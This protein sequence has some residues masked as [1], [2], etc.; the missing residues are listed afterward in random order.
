MQHHKIKSHTKTPPENPGASPSRVGGFLTPHVFPTTSPLRGA[1][2]GVRPV[3]LRPPAS[4]DRR[5]A[6]LKVLNCVSSQRIVVRGGIARGCSSAVRHVVATRCV[7]SFKILII[8][9]MYIIYYSR[10]AFFIYSFSRVH[11]IS[12]VSRIVDSFAIFLM[13]QLCVDF[14]APFTGEPGSIGRR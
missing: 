1:Q 14:G 9:K 2:H 12:A 4:T 3:G 5:Q 7:S 11:I 13:M 6:V 8:P 10:Y